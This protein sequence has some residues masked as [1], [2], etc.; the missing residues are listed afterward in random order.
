MKIKTTLYIYHVQYSWMK[1]PEYQ[2]FSFE[3]PKDDSRALMCSHEIEIEVP[4][5][6]DPREQQIEAL[7]EQK[8]DIMAQYQKSITKIDSSISKLQAISYTE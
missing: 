5:N 2:V 6:F 7:L 3:A 8:K 1:E 4:D